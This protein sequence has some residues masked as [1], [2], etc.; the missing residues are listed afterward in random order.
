MKRKD[1]IR[2][3]ERAG[4]RL[5]RHGGRHDIWINPV[6]GLK[7]PVPRHV[8]IDNQLANHIMKYLGLN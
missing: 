6:N 8:E 4:C 5:H 1:L 2:M 3:L 7:Q